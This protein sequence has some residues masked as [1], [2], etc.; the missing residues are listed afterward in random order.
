MS[1]SDIRDEGRIKKAIL[2]KN[3]REIR[4]L[5][6]VSDMNREDIIKHSIEE[7]LLLVAK[8]A[9]GADYIANTIRG[10]GGDAKRAWNS[11]SK[12]EQHR[13]FRYLIAQPDVVE[14]A[15][16][17]HVKALRELDD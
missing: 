16:P 4:L 11:L 1:Y 8:D 12:E 17:Q 3:K 5:V 7:H 14:R 6:I 9:L 15:F 13:V 2:Y 10:A